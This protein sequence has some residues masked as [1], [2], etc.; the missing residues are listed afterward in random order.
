M[1]R[2]EWT[3]WTGLTQWT[4]MGARAVHEVNAVPEVQP[5]LP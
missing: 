4:G 2:A 1:M 3:E 5:F